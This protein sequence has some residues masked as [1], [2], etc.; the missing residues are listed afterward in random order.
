[1]S[2]VNSNESVVYRRVMSNENCRSVYSD[3]DFSVVCCAR[4]VKHLEL[5][6][7]IYI[8]LSSPLLCVQK[9]SVATLV[10]LANLSN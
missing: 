9:T 4:S 3:T 1:M 10:L 6:E 2:A 7:S 8:G 5:L